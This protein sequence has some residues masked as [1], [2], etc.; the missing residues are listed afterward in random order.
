MILLVIFMTM[1][2]R[3]MKMTKMASTMMTVVVVRIHK[4]MFKQARGG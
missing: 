2:M 4:I 1:T 3:K